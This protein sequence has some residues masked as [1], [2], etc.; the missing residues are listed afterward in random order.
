MFLFINCILSVVL[1]DAFRDISILQ[2]K[3]WFA[4]TVRH[5]EHTGSRCPLHFYPIRTVGRLISTC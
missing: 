5:V 4:D 1:I 3:H 2:I